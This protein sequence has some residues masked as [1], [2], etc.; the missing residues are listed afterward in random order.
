MFLILLL[1][2]SKYWCWNFYHFFLSSFCF[3]SSYILQNLLYLSCSI[4]PSFYRLFIPQLCSFICVHP[5]NS[6]SGIYCSNS[7]KYIAKSF[8]LYFWYIKNLKILVYLQCMYSHLFHII[9]LMLLCFSSFI[10][11]TNFS[12]LCHF[13][14]KYSIY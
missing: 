5:T 3:N 10:F 6:H 8:A 4:F 14:I 9:W 11:F 2:C 12:F 7:L 13:T 1:F